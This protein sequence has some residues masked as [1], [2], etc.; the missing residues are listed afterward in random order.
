SWGWG[1][2]PYAGWG[3]NAWGHPGYGYGNHYYGGNYYGGN[4]YRVRPSGAP[5][6]IASRSGYNS[7]VGNT[8]RVSSSRVARDRNGRI[9]TGR[10]S[11]ATANGTR[12]AVGNTSRVRSEN[13]RVTRGTSN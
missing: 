10:T 12:S 7:R 9:V 6:R 13:G 5:T 11:R 3:Y 8:S 2:Y 4:R 1:G